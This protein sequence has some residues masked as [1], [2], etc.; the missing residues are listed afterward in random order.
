MNTMT[1][2]G[3]HLLWSFTDWDMGTGVNE[4]KEK[5]QY[6]SGYMENQ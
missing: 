1:L 6:L 2:F 5:E 4:K 3:H